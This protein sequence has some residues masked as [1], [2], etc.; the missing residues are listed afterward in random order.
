MANGRS[1]AEA[2]LAGGV[3]LVPDAAFSGVY[4][5]EMCE[6]HCL[7]QKMGPASYLMQLEE[8]ER[9]YRETIKDMV[10]DGDRCSVA[11]VMG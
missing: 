7:D 10:A 5:E 2:T 1:S 11:C 6:A 8:E 9:Q 3:D 4:C